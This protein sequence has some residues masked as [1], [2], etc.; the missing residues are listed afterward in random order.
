MR[1]LNTNRKTLMTAFQYL[2]AIIFGIS[3]ASGQILFKIAATQSSP[4]GEQLTVVRTL[5]TWPM[6]LALVIYGLS[7]VLYTYLL[8]QVPLSRAYMFSLAASTIVP[9]LA[10]YLFDEPFNLRYL[11]GALLVLAGVIIST[12][13]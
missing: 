9:I 12:S 5:V 7:V 2:L 3:L 6:L 8:Q 11:F 4:A 1:R 13:S 10:V